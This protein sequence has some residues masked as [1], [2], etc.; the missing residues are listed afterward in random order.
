M[1]LRREDYAAHGY[2]IGCPGCRALLR[3]VAPQTHSEPCRH[4]MEDI[5]KESEAGQQRKRVADEK[6]YQRLATQ[7]EED[8]KK[9]K[10]LKTSVE[11][12]E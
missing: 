4:R 2:T 3:G 8:D 10:R 11:Y 9:N 12:L 7:V 1:R 6:I 5:L